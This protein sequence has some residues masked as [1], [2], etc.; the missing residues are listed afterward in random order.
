MNKGD[1]YH[2]QILQIILNEGYMDENADGTPAHTLSVNHIMTQYDLA[3]GE[4]PMITTRP[5]A[6]KSAIK[7]ILW[8]YQDQTSD[9]SVLE[10]KYGIHWWNQWESK[11]RPGT[12][13]QRYGATVKKYDLINRLIKDIKENPYGRRKV[14]SMW[15]E[16]DFAET[17]GLCPCCY[18]TIWNVRGEYLDMMMNQRSSDFVTAW[19]INEIQYIAFQMMISHE[20]GYKPGVFTHVMGNVQIY[21][22]HV[23]QAK[24]LVKRGVYEGNPRLILNAEG[25]GFYDIQMEDFQMY[26]YPANLIK[27]INPQMEL[28][29]GI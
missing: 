23:E 8:I 7:E 13:G 15:Q 1:L 16:N 19:C 18:E 22:R 14:M 17:D 20:C 29:L 2:K 10:E 12:I 6:W 21:D 27:T 3:A 26:D 11:T 24:E 9:L 5:I 28:E 4:F 25:K